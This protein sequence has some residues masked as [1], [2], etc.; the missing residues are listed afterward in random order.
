MSRRWHEC[1]FHNCLHSI[2][3]SNST[4]SHSQRTKA[5]DTPVTWN[6][7]SPWTV[8]LNPHCPSESLGPSQT[9][10]GPGPSQK[11][12]FQA[13]W[14]ERT[15]SSQSPLTQPGV[16]TTVPALVHLGAI[17]QIRTGRLSTG[18][19]PSRTSQPPP[20]EA[21]LQFSLLLG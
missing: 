4:Q 19:Q 21:C 13:V 17:H 16:R 5:E 3:E 2:L 15:R 10:R 11:L 9:Q 18:I 7:H 12:L 14:S 6:S 20:P 1:N 8:V